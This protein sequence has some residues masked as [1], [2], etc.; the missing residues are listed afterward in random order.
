[1]PRHLISDAHE[2]INEILPVPTL[3]FSETTVKGT[4]LNKTA[5]KEDPVAFDSSLVGF[6]LT[7][8]SLGGSS[9]QP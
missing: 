9:L 5:G 7:R 1:M 6:K 8:C 2:W 3:H 4:G